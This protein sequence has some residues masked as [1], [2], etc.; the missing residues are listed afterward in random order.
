MKENSVEFFYS[1]DESYT[2]NYYVADYDKITFGIVEGVLTLKGE[3]D[4]RLLQIGRKSDKVAK[5]D[6][7]LPASFAGKMDVETATGF[8]KLNNFTSLEEVDLSTATGTLELTNTNVTSNV[9]LN[10]ATGNVIVNN[11]HCLNLTSEIATGRIEVKNSTVTNK[12]DSSTGTGKI[13]YENATAASIVGDT[14]TGSIT[15][16]DC[17]TNSIDVGTATG[18]ITISLTGN[19]DD[20]S[21]DL[22]VSTG[23]IKFQDT[24]TKGSLTVNKGSKQIKAN[25]STGDITVTIHN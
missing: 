14:G 4:F 20:Y 23:D 16:T 3:R 1:S 12:I 15:V 24:T 17:V 11:V 13:I 25:S 6:V 19:E 7:Y 18:S 2:V 21:V 5:I 22:D 10:T 9:N 8:I